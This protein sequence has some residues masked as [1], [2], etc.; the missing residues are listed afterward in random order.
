MNQ[1]QVIEEQTE[2]EQI[3]QFKSFTVL[4]NI[5][6]QLEWVHSLK[7]RELKSSASFWNSYFH[8]KLFT[9]S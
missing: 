5:Q 4:D 8:L 6:D 7:Q 1:E 3:E 9:L 2:E